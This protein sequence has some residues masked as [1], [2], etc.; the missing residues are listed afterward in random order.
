MLPL[1]KVEIKMLPFK[2]KKLKKLENVTLHMWLSELATPL[3]LSQA[4]L[5]FWIQLCKDRPLPPHQGQAFPC[6]RE[7]EQLECTT[8]E[9]RPACKGRKGHDESA[10]FSSRT[11]HGKGE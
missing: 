1:K 6:G 8:S 9:D 2:K 3:S 7:Q 10:R 4:D 11:T 5:S